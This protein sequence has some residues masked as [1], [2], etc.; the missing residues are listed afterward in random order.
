MFIVLVLYCHMTNNHNFNGSK[1]HLFILQFLS[2][3]SG[4]L[5]WVFCH[6]AAVKV[7]AGTGVSSVDQCCLQ[8][9]YELLAEFSSLQL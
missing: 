9:A 2:Q 5:N 1:Q 6:K 7:A 8:R 4:H 3:E